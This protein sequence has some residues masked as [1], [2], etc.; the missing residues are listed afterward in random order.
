MNV[1]PCRTRCRGVGDG[2]LGT[3]PGS[4]SP[5][6]HNDNIH[7]TGMGITKIKLFESRWRLTVRLC[8]V[9]VWPHVLLYVPVAKDQT[10][11]IGYR[12]TVMN[13]SDFF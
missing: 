4:A 7:R 1:S 10:S 2:F 8:V 3:S 11:W 12:E 5:I 6:A 9:G 13:D